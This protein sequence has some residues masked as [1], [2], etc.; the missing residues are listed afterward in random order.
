MF[1]IKKCVR[2]IYIVRDPVHVWRSW[3]VSHVETNLES[4]PRFLHG[5]ILQAWLWNCIT[6]S[7]K[8]ISITIAVLPLWW[9][10]KRLASVLI[11]KMS[12]DTIGFRLRA[13]NEN[14]F[15]LS[16]TCLAHTPVYLISESSFRKLISSGLSSG[17]TTDL[18]KTIK[19]ASTV[20]TKLK[21]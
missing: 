9:R 16:S 10:W 12:H 14:M 18:T 2:I 5:E 19:I 15:N 4:L 17:A 8:R 1:G 6:K 13:T 21:I 11:G 20:V 7:V 3:K